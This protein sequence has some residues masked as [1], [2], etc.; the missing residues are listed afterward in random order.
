MTKSLRHLVCD[1][2]QMRGPKDVPATSTPILHSHFKEVSTIAL[3]LE[4][5]RQVCGII[6]GIHFFFWLEKK[7]TIY[8]PLPFAILQGDRMLPL[9][10]AILQ[11]D[12]MLKVMAKSEKP[13]NQD[14]G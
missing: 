12:R 3:T 5:Q 8:L 2:S 4:L 9:P 11:G 1:S 6:L 7:M 13:R 10:F 14:E